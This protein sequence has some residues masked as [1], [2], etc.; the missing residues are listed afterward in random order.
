MLQR[1]NASIK[2]NHVL[3]EQCFHSALSR[4]EDL[5]HPCNLEI[6]YTE[7]DTSRRILFNLTGKIPVR[8]C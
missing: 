5:K 3:L 1:P 6:S 7:K 2:N 4:D 8:Y